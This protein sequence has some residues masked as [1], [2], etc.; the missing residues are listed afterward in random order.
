MESME[1]MT[2][3]SAEREVERLEERLAT[4]EAERNTIKRI[5]DATQDSLLAAQ[6]ENAELR[7]QLAEMQEEIEK[8]EVLGI[9]AGADDPT[10]PESILTAILHMQPARR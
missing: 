9:A 4:I 6:A 7:R 3:H 2:F 8:F 1:G 10:S 5:C